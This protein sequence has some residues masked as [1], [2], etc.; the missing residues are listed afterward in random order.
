MR[1]FLPRSDKVRPLA[2]ICAPRETTDDFPHVFLCGILLSPPQLHPSGIPQVCS[3]F[4]GSYSLLDLIFFGLHFQQNGLAAA[5]GPIAVRE[6]K[7]T[8]ERRCFLAVEK[9]RLHS[10]GP[11]FGDGVEN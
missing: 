6:S 1:L 2:V 11:V 4:L 3:T 5:A 10:C 7:R 9:S 8:Y